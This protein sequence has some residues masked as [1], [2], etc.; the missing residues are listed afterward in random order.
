M[1]CR[2]AFG[3]NFKVTN[4]GFDDEKEYV[5]V[6][7]TPVSLGTNS[8][9]IVL[10]EGMEVDIKRKAKMHETSSH[11]SPTKPPLS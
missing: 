9:P 11:A 8:N 2:V 6:V 10:E 7:G 3:I 1:L 4:W 5:E